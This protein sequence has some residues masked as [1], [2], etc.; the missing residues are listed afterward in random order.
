MWELTRPPLL[1]VTSIGK[2]QSVAAC[3]YEPTEAHSAAMGTK[4]RE[5]IYGGSV[6]HSAERAK[7]ARKEADRLACV[8]WN[9][10]MLGLKGPAQPS[11]AR[12]GGDALNAGHICPGLVRGD[13]F[14]ARCVLLNDE[15]KL[16]IAS[17]SQTLP[18]RLMLQTM[19]LSAIRRWNC[20]PA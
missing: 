1:S 15:K 10:R 17:L 6:R 2:P 9:Q 14:C 11:P 19:P 13:R 12:G 16:S 7:E 8:A 20:S 4:S 5:S 3:R 18:E